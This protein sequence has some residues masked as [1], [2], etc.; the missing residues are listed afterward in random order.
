MVGQLGKGREG[1]RWSFRTRCGLV[2][3]G[4]GFAWECWMIPRDIIV[5]C[6]EIVLSDEIVFNA[7]QE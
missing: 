6:I 4:H 5:A 7:P 3:S 2:W 1:L